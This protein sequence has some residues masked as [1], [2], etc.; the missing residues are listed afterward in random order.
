[1]N[2]ITHEQIL[3]HLLQGET[4]QLPYEKINFLIQLK[5]IAEAF[6]RTFSP[7]RLTRS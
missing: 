6:K 4:T 3:T 2:T 7:R 5:N 1:M